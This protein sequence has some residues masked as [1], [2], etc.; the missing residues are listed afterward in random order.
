M[1]SPAAPSL[2]VEPGIQA[3]VESVLGKS[4]TLSD[5]I[6]CGLRSRDEARRAHDCVAADMLSLA[7]SAG[8]MLHV[9]ACDSADV[10][11]AKAGAQRVEPRSRERW[12]PAFAGMTNPGLFKTSCV[13]ARRCEDFLSAARTGPPRPFH[14]MAYDSS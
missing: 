3:E 13:G 9:C 5:F 11:P 4:E 1:K 7:C 12:I 10:V 6:A 14:E 2:R 8:W